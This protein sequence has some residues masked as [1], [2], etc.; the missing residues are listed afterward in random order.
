M[1]D[2]TKRLAKRKTELTTDPV[3]LYNTLDRASDKGPLRPAQEVVLKR[4]HAEYASKKDAILKLHTGQ[5]KTLIGLLILQSRLNGGQGPA[6]Y[7]CPNRFLVNQTCSQAKQFGLSVCTAD[8]DLPADFVNRKSILVTTVQKL[9]NG[10]TEFGLGN[11]AQEVGAI[12]IDD[13]H[14]CVDAIRNA[15]VIHLDKD[16]SAYSSIQS[17]FADELEKQGVGTFA[18]IQNGDRDAILPVP[19]WAW[20]DRTSEVAKILAAR[21]TC[22]GVRFAWPLLRDILDKCQCVVSGAAL[23]IVP[24]LPPLHMFK[25]YEQAAVRVFMSATV[26]DDSFLVRGLGIAPDVVRAPLI[27]E[28]ERWSGEKMVL[29]P[30]L[31]DESLDRAQIIT[32]LAKPGKK[33]PYGVVALAPSFKHAR[34][35]KTTA[36]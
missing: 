22:K 21:S 12:V 27:Y 34:T 33:R 4:W 29:I 32:W 11:N 19:Y 31:I 35:G 30:S 9:F 15:F 8:D 7:L 6:L 36:P 28:N 3:N 14:A 16:E 24:Y 26:A 1:V 23:E 18:G 10:Q 5:G 20:Q 13:A 17:L 25:S 2:F